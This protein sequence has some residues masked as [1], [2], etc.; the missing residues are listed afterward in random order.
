MW[1][2]EVIDP[3]HANGYG[4]VINDYFL[5]RTKSFSPR[6]ALSDDELATENITRLEWWRL[7]DITGYHGTDLFSPR[8]LAR[9]L[10]TL[11]SSGLPDSPVPLGL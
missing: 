11:I 9:L 10:A 5:I 2:Q 3:G 8:D 6:G 4:G 1:H 7:Q